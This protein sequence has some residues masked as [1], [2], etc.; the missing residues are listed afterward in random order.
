M[1]KYIWQ[2]RT[3]QDKENALSFEAIGQFYQILHQFECRNT[4]WLT[5]VRIDH[6]YMSSDYRD[7]R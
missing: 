1:E 2:E 7:S 3:Q 5:F 4:N 6:I